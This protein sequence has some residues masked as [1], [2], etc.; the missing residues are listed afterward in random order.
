MFKPRGDEGT[1]QGLGR[2]RTRVQKETL[3]VFL[4]TYIVWLP[5]T[6]SA[7]SCSYYLILYWEHFRCH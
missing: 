6:V 3:A 7:K 5:L 4:S 2:I 1:L